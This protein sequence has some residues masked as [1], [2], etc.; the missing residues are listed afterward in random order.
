MNYSIMQ[1]VSKQWRVLAAI[2]WGLSIGAV[3]IH[4]LTASY[5]FNHLW[6]GWIQ[7]IMLNIV[8]LPV[9]VDPTEIDFATV[10]WKAWISLLSSP[11]FN[12]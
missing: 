4:K 7:G 2:S 6:G 3:Q 5:N 10:A 9:S 8:T 11:P 1:R 12:N